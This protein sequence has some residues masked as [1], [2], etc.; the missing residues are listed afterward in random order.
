MTTSEFI[1]ELKEKLELEDIELR[2][3]TDLSELEEYDS[4]AVMAMIALIDELFNKK[5]KSDQ[6]KS[7]TTVQS[8]IEMIGLESFND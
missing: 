5:L 6:F 3:E 7:I 2:P 1:E 8:L 4:I